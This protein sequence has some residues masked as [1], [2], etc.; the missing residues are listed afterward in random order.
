MTPSTTSR[1]A[2]NLTEGKFSTFDGGITRTN[3]YHPLWLFLITPFYWVFDREAAL[4]AIKAFEIMLIAGGVALVTA[5]VRLARMPRYLMFAALPVLYHIPFLIAGMEA[6]VALFML[7]LLILA[8]CLFARSPVRW[9]WPLAAVAFALPWVRLEYAAISLA[10]TAALCLIEWSWQERA[11]SASAGE[12]ARSARSVKAVVPLLAAGAGILVYFAYNW[13]VFGG[14]VPVSAA[15]KNF[16]SQVRW[17]QE[18][19]YS[20]TQ[21]FQDTL[22]I[23][24]FLI[25]YKAHPVSECGPYSGK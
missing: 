9:Q 7:G 13:L 15:T 23:S 6:A 21:N 19:G 12:R 24:V 16:R 8:A 3:G 17:E 10:A 5:A 1:F 25:T 20:L 18:G 14:I 11:P 4:F 22:Q 2:R